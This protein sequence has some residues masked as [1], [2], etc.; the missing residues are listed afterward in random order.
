M[1]A[2]R[3]ELHCKLIMTAALHGTLRKEATQTRALR[4]SQIVAHSSKLFANGLQS[5][6]SSARA[7]R[8]ACWLPAR[9][10][11]L[12]GGAWGCLAAWWHHLRRRAIILVPLYLLTPRIAHEKKTEAGLSRRRGD[13]RPD[14]CGASWLAR[15]LLVILI[16]IILLILILI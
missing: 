8:R 13:T 6:G 10:A 9:Q 11:R 7:G 12:P 1:L 14:A 3:V 16:T 2:S 5:I 15:S 4:I